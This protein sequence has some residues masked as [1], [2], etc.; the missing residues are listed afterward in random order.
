M[1]VVAA[2]VKAL[3]SELA[4]LSD[5]FVNIYLDIAGCLID[6]DAWGDCADQALKLMTAHLLTL[7]T[8]GGG[9]GGPVSSERVG[10]LAIQYGAITGNS[11]I[12]EL[13]GTSYG[14]MLAQLRRAKFFLPLCV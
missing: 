2:D 12:Q 8:R 10:D 5:S 1:A 3:G 6:A 7:A 13:E 4:S 14:V 9:S 11:D